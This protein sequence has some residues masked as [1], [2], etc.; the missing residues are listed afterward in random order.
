MPDIASCL[1]VGEGA[2]KKRRRPERLEQFPVRRSDL[3]QSTEYAIG[4]ARAKTGANTQVR[5][6]FAGNELAPVHRGAP[7]KR[8]HDGGSHRYD[9][10]SR[11]PRL[12]D[13]VYGSLRQVEPFRKRQCGIDCGVAGRR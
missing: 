11:R 6:R 13:C 12:R 4:D 3:M 7:F 10:P 2:R 1:G 8:A 5:G 9:A